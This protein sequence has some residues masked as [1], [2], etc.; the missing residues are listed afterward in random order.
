MNY[1]NDTFLIVL[2]KSIIEVSLKCHRDALIEWNYM[3]FWCCP[4]LL[5][6]TI[7]GQTLLWFAICFANSQM[8]NHNHWQGEQKYWN[9]ARCLPKW[10]TLLA[11]NGHKHWQNSAQIIHRMNTF[12]KEWNNKR[13][14]RLLSVENAWCFDD[15]SML[16]NR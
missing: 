13:Q 1:V 2:Q 6:Q 16:L 4:V 5:L 10:G 14:N 12:V 8:P 11:P 15:K 9:W 7:Y 3:L